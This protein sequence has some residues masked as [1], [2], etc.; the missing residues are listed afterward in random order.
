MNAITKLIPLVLM[1]CLSISF[2]ALAKGPSSAGSMTNQASLNIASL[3]DEEANT[4]LWMREEEK[5][6]RDVYGAMYKVWKQRVFKN[7]AASEQRHMDAVLKK[8]N[9]FGLPDPALPEAGR[10]TNPNLQAFYDQSIAQGEQSYI[11]ALRAGATI[12]DV[13]IRDLL[14]AIEATN[15]LA[16]KTTYQNLLEGSKN[17][18]RAFVGLLRKQGVEYSPQYIEQ[19]LFDAILGF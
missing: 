10:F 3:S 12:E 5:M 4:L 1:M 17:H 7:I 2:P 8:L 14:A 16:L 9:L 15:N 6:A 19:A 13:D 11:D 18:L